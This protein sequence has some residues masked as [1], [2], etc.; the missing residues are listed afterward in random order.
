[1]T[2]T[3]LAVLLGGAG[4]IVAIYWW[5]FRAGRKVIGR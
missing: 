4:L 3:D 5:F 1:M 2:T